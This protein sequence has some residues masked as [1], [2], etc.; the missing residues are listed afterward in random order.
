M[1]M[2]VVYVKGDLLTYYN[3]LHVLTYL[4]HIWIK[5]LL[6]RYVVYNE[7]MNGLAKCVPI[8]SCHVN[9]SH[10]LWLYSNS[11]H[12]HVLCLNES[13]VNGNLTYKHYEVGFNFLVT[14]E[15]M[16]VDHDK[17]LSFL[18]HHKSSLWKVLLHKEPHPYSIVMDIYDKY[19]WN[20]SDDAPWL[21]LIPPAP[22]GPNM[23][24]VQEL[25]VT[26]DFFCMN[27]IK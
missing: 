10:G 25:F 16:M 27:E 4:A 8:S 9:I 14:F 19:V 26:K 20:Q 13:D 21:N 6:V 3:M 7:H 24:K 2:M 23:L 5:T 11:H 15:Y 18:P 1:C 22:C 12:F 17:N